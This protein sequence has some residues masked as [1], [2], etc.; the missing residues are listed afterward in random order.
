MERTKF[1]KNLTASYFSEKMVALQQEHILLL[2]YGVPPETILA[3]GSYE[4]ERRSESLFVEPNRKHVWKSQQKRK[5]S[6]HAIVS[7]EAVLDNNTFA[8]FRFIAINDT[9]KRLTGITAKQA[10]C[11]MANE[12]W[13]DTETHWI[14]AYTQLTESG[15]PRAFTLYHSQISKF[16]HCHLFNPGH[17]RSIFFVIFTD[18]TTQ[19]E[20]DISLIQ[21][22]G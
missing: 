3:Q 17:S 13:P 12:I 6:R 8:G 15:S 1:S 4:S 5:R 20:K 16:Y 19:K 7:I 18:I 21:Q 9:F 11:K 10:Q 2:H 22:E 14:K